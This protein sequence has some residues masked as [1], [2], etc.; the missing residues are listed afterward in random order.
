VKGVRHSRLEQ[1]GRKWSE[2]KNEPGFMFVER[3][4]ITREEDDF[5]SAFES[6]ECFSNPSLILARRFG[7]TPAA[8]ECRSAALILCCLYSPTRRMLLATARYGASR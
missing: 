8:T 4:G 6:R 2:L 7:I 1:R 5:L 3:A